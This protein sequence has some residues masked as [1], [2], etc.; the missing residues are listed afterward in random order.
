MESIEYEQDYQHRIEA[1]FDR[2]SEKFSLGILREMYFKIFLKKD[3]IGFYYVIMD[4]VD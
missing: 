2:E 3:A 1:S 4:G